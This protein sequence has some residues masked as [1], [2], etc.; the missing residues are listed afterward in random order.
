MIQYPLQG[1]SWIEDSRGQEA[2]QNT[3]WRIQRL[4]QLL[5]KD[6]DHGT[7]TYILCMHRTQ[8]FVMSAE[9]QVKWRRAWPSGSSKRLL[10]GGNIRD[11][12]IEDLEVTLRSEFQVKTHGWNTLMYRCRIQRLRCVTLISVEDPEASVWF[13]TAGLRG[14]G[15]PLNRGSRGFGV[16]P[17]CRT[18]R[19]RCAPE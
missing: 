5:T 11:R 15:A 18:Q 10:L 19:P 13:L 12:W 6:P 14:R 16:V 9:V 3:L 4:W 2:G 17:D 1:N 7:A 8:K